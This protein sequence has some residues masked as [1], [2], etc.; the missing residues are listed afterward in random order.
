M[1]ISCPIVT[2]PVPPTPVTT[3]RTR[4]ALATTEPSGCGKLG[5][6]SPPRST[7]PFFSCP[8]S[9]VTKLGQNPFRHE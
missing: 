7:C 6:L 3:F 2:T 8:P 4:L 9:T 1:P 5:I